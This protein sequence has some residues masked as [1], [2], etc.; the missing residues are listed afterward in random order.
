MILIVYE[1]NIG[2]D[3]RHADEDDTDNDNNLEDNNLTGWNGLN[4]HHSE[5]QR[6][7]CLVCIY[8]C[9]NITPQQ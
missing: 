2:G 3:E 8:L 1:R 6:Y 9:G 7:T 4:F 5:P